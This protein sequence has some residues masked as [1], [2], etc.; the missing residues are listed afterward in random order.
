MLPH[1][2]SFAAVS[3]TAASRPQHMAVVHKSVAYIAGCGVIVGCVDSL[4]QLQNQRFF[5]APPEIPL[6]HVAEQDIRRDAFGYA[7]N[8]T[9][10]YRGSNTETDTE[11]RDATPAKAQNRARTPTCIALLPNG[12]VLALGEA[13]FQPRVLL[14]SLAPD[15]APRPFAVIIEHSFAVKHLCFSPNLRLLCSLGSATDG[16]LH[17]WR[18]SPLAVSVRA[19]NKCSS[20]VNDLIW[21][22]LASESGTIVTAGLRF[23]KVWLLEHAALASPSKLAVL[24]GRNIILG[25]YLDKNFLLALPL[26]PERILL[27]DGNE[28]FAVSLATATVTPVARE[29]DGFMGLVLDKDVIWYFSSKLEP[30]SLR[31]AELDGKI[32][33]ALFSGSSP[34]KQATSLLNLDAAD[35]HDTIVKAA[36]LPSRDI[37]LLACNKLHIHHVATQTTEDLLVHGPTRV[38][39]AKLTSKGE[40]LVFSKSGEVFL[41]TSASSLLL[42]LVNLVQSDQLVNEL[43]AVEKNAD[44]LFL[45]NKF[46]Q[47]TVLDLLASNTPEL[48]IKAHSSAINEI[49]YF[50]IAGKELLCSISRDRMIQLYYKNPEWDILQTLS[51][52]TA[53]IMT[54]RVE[55]NTLF[56]CSA[57]RS[58]SIHEIRDNGLDVHHKKTIALKN[59]PTAMEVSSGNLVISTSDKMLSIYDS[60]SLGLKKTFKLCHDG[61]SLGIE[62]LT[63]LPNEVVAVYCSDRSLRTFELMSGKMLGC[64]WGH[65]EVV[66][67]IFP[68]EES[69][70]SLG[71]DGCL[72]EW[73]LSAPEPTVLTGKEPSTSPLEPESPLLAKVTRKILPTVYPRSPRRALSASIEDGNETDPESPTP[74]GRLTRATLKRLEAR[75][76]SLSV[77]PEKSAALSL[78]RSPGKSAIS[79][80]SETPFSRS[81]TRLS[82]SPTR[83]FAVAAK[84]AVPRASDTVPGVPKTHTESP[85]TVR[86]KVSPVKDNSGRVNLTKNA[87]PPPDQLGDAKERTLAYLT[88]VRS[89]ISK[90]LLNAAEKEEIAKELEALLL[91]LGVSSTQAILEKYSDSLVELVERKLQFRE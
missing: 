74:T 58:I 5:V 63:L 54:V 51:I 23:L 65:L 44:V 55:G 11:C 76:G 89:F 34:T 59:T 26:G 21:V 83:G 56:V 86:S 75:R 36:I 41:M 67:G 12:R 69:I 43:T 25:R 35:K 71:A 10:V 91:L 15:L 72:F 47:M 17:V 19:S 50:E 88:L 77:S 27:R 90:D 87:L 66:H 70:L 85:V 49:V 61:E 24:K 57:D 60:C 33:P 40:V 48:T 7:T 80:P 73:R 2:L 45:G 18:F 20:V 16:F 62:K 39:G 81:P 30:R 38:A 32:D 52:H 9:I 22:E 64:A 6:D 28:L 31:M 46:G 84:K 82:S 37:V 78:S 4:G 53:N 68:S 29:L 8:H 1:G 42:A 14:F 3:G 13:G 79:R